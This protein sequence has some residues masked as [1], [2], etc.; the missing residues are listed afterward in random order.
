VQYEQVRNTRRDS[1]ETQERQV[2]VV[3]RGPPLDALMGRGTASQELAPD[4]WQVRAGEPPS[5]PERRGQQGHRRILQARHPSVRP[6]DKV[7]VQVFGAHKSQDTRKALRFFSERRVKVHFVNLM[8]RAASRGE[9]QRFAQRFGVG[10]LVNR[11]SPRYAALGLGAARMDDGRWLETLVQEPLLLA[12]PL[13]RWRDKLTI[14][15]AV[16]DWTEWM[17][18]GKT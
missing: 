18:A 12:M 6:S 15:V 16:E 5:G 10:A 9:L 2:I 7:E 8:E 11:S 4:G 17:R 14:G 1:A 13:V 3:R